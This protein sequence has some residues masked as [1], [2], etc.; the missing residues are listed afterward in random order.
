M[1]RAYDDYE[2]HSVFHAAY[3]FFTVDLSAFY[4]D[5]LKDR[6]YC[7]GKNRPDPAV[8]P[9][10]PVPD[11][12]RF[13]PPAGSAPAV[14]DRGGLGRAARVRRQGGIRPSGAI[15]RSSPRPGFRT[16][17]KRTGTDLLALREKILKELENARESKLIGNALEATSRS[18]ASPKRRPDRIA[19]ERELLAALCIV[20]DGPRRTVRRDGDR[21][22]GRKGGG[23]EMPPLLELFDSRRN[24]RRPIPTSAGAARTSWPGREAAMKRYGLHAALAA[25][26]ILLDQLTK[27]LI[28][29][30]VPF[31]GSVRVIPGF[32][33]L[34]HIHNKGAILGFF[35]QLGTAV[36]ADSPVASERRP[37]SAWSFFIFRKPRTRNGLPVW[38][39]P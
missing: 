13:P 2:F 24:V 19:S 22:P 39:W 14:H 7:S 15:S 10:R 3:N 33:D 30:T 1:L 8:G 16:R 12:A 21:G 28:V 11:P 27:A 31:Y 32:L 5:V 18:C 38:P 29:K 4:L 17:T 26:I 9:D 35:N 25:A 20:S 34:T 37:P 6:L 36:D 23:P